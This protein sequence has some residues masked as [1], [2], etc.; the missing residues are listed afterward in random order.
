MRFAFEG[1]EETMKHFI[2]NKEKYMPKVIVPFWIISSI[3][4]SN[5]RVLFADDETEPR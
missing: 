2:Q 4:Y 3:H 5:N 1:K